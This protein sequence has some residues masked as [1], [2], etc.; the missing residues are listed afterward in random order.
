MSRDHLSASFVHFHSISELSLQGLTF[1]VVATYPTGDNS[2]PTD[3]VVANIGGTDYLY[4]QNQGTTL[5]V[6]SLAG[7]AGNAKIAQTVDLVPNNS[8]NGAGVAV[9]YP[10]HP[11]SSASHSLSACFFLLLLALLL[12]L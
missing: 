11:A 1:S 12:L 2:S 8:T 10:P 3:L 9:Y 7:G 4:V 6:F 5:V